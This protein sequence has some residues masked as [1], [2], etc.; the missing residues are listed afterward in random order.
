MVYQRYEQLVKFLKNE[1]IYQYIEEVC[2]IGQP[3]V[4]ATDDVEP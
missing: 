1:L 2:F 4:Y 3:S